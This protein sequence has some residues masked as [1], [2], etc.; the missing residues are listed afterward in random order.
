MKRRPGLPLT[1]TPSKVSPGVPV[2]KNSTGA[3]RS[4]EEQLVVRRAAALKKQKAA[5]PPCDEPD[6]LRPGTA[7]PFEHPALK[8]SHP[9]PVGELAEAEKSIEKEMHVKEKT[10]TK[11]TAISRL[12]A[13]KGTDPAI[14]FRSIAQEKFL[15]KFHEHLLKNPD[16]DMKAVEA[17]VKAELEAEFRCEEKKKKGIEKMNLCENGAEKTPAKPSN[18]IVG[19][20]PVKTIERITKHLLE[21]HNIEPPKVEKNLRQIPQDAWEVIDLDDADWDFCREVVGYRK[22]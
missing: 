17:D 15:S 10:L 19:K 16:V 8:K 1:D 9:V 20:L 12:E 11:A 13:L 3:V 2:V 21:K 14:Q 7:S 22:I 4:F 6:H 18:K 5:Y